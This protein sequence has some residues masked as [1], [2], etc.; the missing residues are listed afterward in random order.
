[1]DDLIDVKKGTGLSIVKYTG[2][3]NLLLDCKAPNHAWMTGSLIIECHIQW[4]NREFVELNRK[5]LLFV[6]SCSSKRNFPYKY[7]FCIFRHEQASTSRWGRAQGFKTEVPWEIGTMIFTGNGKRRPMKK[8]TKSDAIHKVFR[9]FE[10]EIKQKTI[11]NCFHKAYFGNVPRDLF[12]LGPIELIT[13]AEL[14]QITGETLDVEK[15]I[16]RLTNWY[17]YLNKIS[18]QKNKIF[19]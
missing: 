16:N 14:S 15:T 8:F 18:K 4:L 17:L 6:D 11:K 19:Q 12:E 2:K 1:M 9:S 10:W 5:S 13:W 3:P 7:Q